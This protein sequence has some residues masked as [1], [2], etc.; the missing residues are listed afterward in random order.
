MLAAVFVAVAGQ[1][2]V[3][4]FGSAIRLSTTH[5][6][7]ALAV[8]AAESVVEDLRAT[9]FGEVVLRFDGDPQNDP[10][11]PG[12]APGSGF[13]VRGLTPLQ[14]DADGLQ[15]R[16]EFPGDGVLLLESADDP[17]LGMPRDLNGDGAIDEI[18]HSTDYRLLPVRVVVE[19]T[20]AA[21]PDELVL[22]TTLAGL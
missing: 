19:W 11:G 14:G 17:Q 8:E 20:G 16:V 2:I 6:E 4:S 15:G 21:G 7:R 1:Q 3:A 13:E 9:P 18:D 5:R 10:A 22:V 12:T